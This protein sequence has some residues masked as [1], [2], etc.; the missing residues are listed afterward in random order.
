MFFCLGSGALNDSDDIGYVSSGI[1]FAKTGVISIWTSNPTAMIMPGMP[2]LTGLFSR[3]FGEGNLYIDAVRCCWICF[4]CVTIYLFY[5]CCRFFAGKW[6]SL[7]SSCCFLLLNW[8]WSDN[9]FLTEP[10]YLMFYMLNFLFML[11][12]GENREN[13]RKGC[14]IGYA[15]SFMGALMFRANI[16]TMPF[17][18]A[19]YLFVIKKRKLRDFI[20]HFA[21]LAAALLMF[22]IPWSVRN[23]RLFNEFIPLTGGSANPLL[24]GTYQGKSAPSDEE[25]DYDTNVTAV[26]RERYPEYFNE[27]GTIRDGVYP[28]IVSAHSDKIKAEYRF[29]E[30]LRCDPAGLI[31][32]YLV[33]KPACMLNWV[34]CWLPNMTIYYS[35]AAFSIAN[36]AFCAFT[37]L[38]CFIRKKNR[39]ELAFL[40]FMYVF[41]IYTFAFSF[42]SERYAAMSV[43]L[44]YFIAAFGIDLILA[45][46]GGKR[47]RVP[48]PQA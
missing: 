6:A 38:V 3:I 12:M 7:L 9:T 14:I 18:A 15:L 25:L 17:F 21:C 29:R 32:S 20:P 40:T 30:W 47:R 19:F 45:F 41:N 5:R 13:E 10:P 48:S 11:K 28:E 1:V 46:I 37:L 44:R 35:L 8:A 42:A 4:G 36:L 22:V 39:A 24:L 16:L 34:W 31:H 26:L 27:D 2:V 43:P 23:Y 33:S